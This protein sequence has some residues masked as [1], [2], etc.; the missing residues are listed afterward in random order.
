MANNSGNKGA[1][2]GIGSALA[3]KKAGAL[4]TG[5]PAPIGNNNNA[6]RASSTNPALGTLA[7]PQKGPTLTLGGA[8]KNK[9]SQNDGAYKTTSG[10]TNRQNKGNASSTR[11]SISLNTADA[12][13]QYFRNITSSQA[14]RIEFRNIFENIDREIARENN[15]SAEQQEI[16]KDNYLGDKS[17]E[18]MADITVPVVYP[19]TQAALAYLVGV[20]LTGNPIFQAVADVANEPAAVQMNAVTTDQS[21]KMGWVRHLSLLI[22]D[23]LK[24][25]LGCVEAEWIQKLTYSL[26]TDT[27][28]NASTA[29]ASKNTQIQ[30]EGNGIKRIDLYNAFWD[31]RVHPAEIHEKGEYCGYTEIIS[32]VALKAEVANLPQGSTMNLTAA[33]ESFRGGI[34]GDLYYVPQVTKKLNTDPRMNELNWMNWA[35]NSKNRSTINYKGVYERT[36]L[37]ARIIPSDFDLNVPAPNSVQIWKFIIINGMVLIHAERQT[38]A[39][40]YFPMLFCQPLEDGLDYQTK[41]FSENI[42][43][44]QTMASQLWNIRISSARRNVMDRAIYDPT[45]IDP[46]DINSSSPNAKIPMRP[47]SYGRSITDSFYSIPYNDQSSASLIPDA[48]RIVDLGRTTTGINAPQEG[49]FI[50]GNR[51]GQEFQTISENANNRLQTMAQFLEA[52]F[53][54]PL[55]EIIKI[56]NL[57]YQKPGSYYS[58]QSKGVVAVNPVEMRQAVMTFKMADGLTPVSKLVDT[59]FLQVVLQASMSNPQ[60]NQEIDVVGVLSYIASLKNVP[61]LAQFRRQQPLQP[62]QGQNNQQSPQGNNNAQA[63]QVQTGAGTGANPAS[64]S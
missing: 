12:V 30:W 47:Q 43:D 39:H 31:T 42:V 64:G 7:A 34:A 18:R 51:T 45:K 4:K 3:N 57:Q 16:Q 37:Y 41:S 24:Y 8:S 9:T 14:P 25:N 20:F 11:T 58:Q 28:P 40:N 23:A 2:T 15:I 21:T 55:K 53:F 60:L 32:R 52:Q 44:I 13:I 50:K 26:T 36:I 61:D 6:I 1:G 56:N 59:D 10:T 33:F 38:N 49:T 22:Y 54:T 5:I 29:G 46:K 19:Q 35:I 17:K 48:L 62:Q 27:S 63:S